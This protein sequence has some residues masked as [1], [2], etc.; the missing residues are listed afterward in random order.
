[1]DIKRSLNGLIGAFEFNC[2]LHL[3]C[4]ISFAHPQ[5]GV[6]R[7][8]RRK[9]EGV[10]TSPRKR[11]AESP[12]KEHRAMPSTS[13]ST[14]FFDL[15]ARTSALQFHK[16]VLAAHCQLAA[17]QWKLENGKQILVYN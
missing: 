9:V 7:S 1:M 8:P 15:Q 17:L 6:E 13:T 16:E 3:P 10:R 12:S 11:K 2:E 14:S 5:C 4:S